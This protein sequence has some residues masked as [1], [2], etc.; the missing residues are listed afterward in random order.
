[1]RFKDEQSLRKGIEHFIKEMSLEEGLNN[2]RAEIAWQEVMGAFVQKY[3]ESVRLK[4]K[5]LFVK[6]NSSA[7][8]QDL[9]YKKDEI[10]KALNK[11][12]DK[13]LISTLVFF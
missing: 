7:L 5:T 4:N 6:L 8:K 13:E 12:L 9:S 1:M 2:E 11:H 3:T 10:T